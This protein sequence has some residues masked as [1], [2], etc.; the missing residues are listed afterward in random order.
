MHQG[1]KVDALEGISDAAE[2]KRACDVV[3]EV[4]R[5]ADVHREED[6]AE[7]CSSGGA[8]TDLPQAGRV[9][10]EPDNS[11][12]GSTKT[13]GANNLLL[14]EL[15]VRK[16]EYTI[17][18][19]GYT[20]V[21]APKCSDNVVASSIRNVEAEMKAQSDL[22]AI[23]NVA[24]PARQVWEERRSRFYDGDNPDVVHGLSESQVIRRVHVARSQHYSGNVHGSIEIPPLSLALDEEVSFFQL[25]Y[26]TVNRDNVTKPTCLLGWAH[27]ALVALLR[28]HGTTLFVDGTF[29]CVPQGYTQC[30]IFMVH[31][32]ASGVR[33]EGKATIGL[34]GLPVDMFDEMS[35]LTTLHISTNVLTRLP[36]LHRLT[37]LKMPA[38]A[39]SMALE[40][41]P[42]FHK[43]ERLVIAITP[44][45]DSLPDFS[46]IQDFKSFVTMDRGTW[47]CNG[48]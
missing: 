27:P 38:L 21:R 18:A 3:E 8:E 28:Y 26:A 33:V 47:C 9:V 48:F 42:A 32:R 24:W 23:E 22:L 15:Q 11:G 46:P 6:M 7:A 30:V 4:G 17:A 41:L 14:Q 44:L 5:E 45:L 35:S 19:M 13:C 36:S 31:D 16:M 40:K 10:S 29:R 43:L 2:E 25:H 34:V 39:A 1:A 12:G 37:N 20:T